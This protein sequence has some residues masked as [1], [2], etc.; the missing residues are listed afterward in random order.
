MRSITLAIY[1]LIFNLMLIFVS[2]F[3]LFSNTTIPGENN[4]GGITFVFLNSILDLINN[5]NITD[6]MA[7][8]LVFGF[9]LY[10]FK[11]MGAILISVVTMSN[12]ILYTVMASF[13]PASISAILVSI[14]LFFVVLDYITYVSKSGNETGG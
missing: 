13:M 6:V 7:G 10:I 1:M 11:P 2:T 3:G 4:N 5:I 8:G 14:T 12:Y 9:L